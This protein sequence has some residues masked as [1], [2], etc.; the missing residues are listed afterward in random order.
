M[1]RHHLFILLSIVLASCS[2][3][4]GFTSFGSRKY[5]KGYFWNNPIAKLEVNHSTSVNGKESVV[6]NNSTTVKVKTETIS[7]LVAPLKVFNSN[8]HKYPIAI[9]QLNGKATGRATKVEMLGDENPFTDKPATNDAELKQERVT[10][11]VMLLI[12]SAL[13]VL[14]LLLVHTIVFLQMVSP[15]TFLIIAS[16]CLIFGLIYL[17]LAQNGTIPVPGADN[18]PVKTGHLGQSGKELAMVCLFISA[19][20]AVTVAIVLISQT[21]ITIPLAAMLLFIAVCVA[22]WI[23][24]QIALHN[25]NEASPDDAKRGLDLA[26]IAL[27]A[28]LLITFVG[29]L[30][31]PL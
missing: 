28:A 2:S 7:K 17:W 19:A 3:N 18:K 1:K 14:G 4:S 31:V 20:L 6:S 27:I 26:T 30:N 10:A 11:G 29:L 25:P 5:T 9:T 8:I 13:S 23:I 21:T 22:A 16:A 12:I 24:C 15:L